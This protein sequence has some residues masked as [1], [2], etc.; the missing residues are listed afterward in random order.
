[1]KLVINYDLITRIQDAKD[2]LGISTALQKNL[3]KVSPWFGVYTLIN[4]ST[5]QPLHR[6]I[7]SA[8]VSAT[9][10]F[11]VWTAMDITKNKMIGNIDKIRALNDLRRLSIKLN[12]LKV[13]TSAELILE[14]EE[15]ARKYKVKVN[16]Q[17]LPYILQEKYI[18][19]PTY[20]NGDIKETSILQEHIIGSKVYV[21]SLGSPTKAFK[22]V[23]A[24]I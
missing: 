4:V 12:D 10:L 15:Y 1:M 21:L 22:P 3:K 19:V 14:S 5:G 20:D 18:M 6:S 8:G 24:G 16:E 13:K 2:N 11:T 7:A 23:F 9:M 17:K